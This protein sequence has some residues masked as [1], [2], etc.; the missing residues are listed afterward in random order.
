MR[1]FSG[2]EISIL[3]VFFFFFLFFK[4]LF[5]LVALKH[6]I[7]WGRNGMILVGIFAPF[8]KGFDK[9]SEI[10][11]FCLKDY[12]HRKIIR[13]VDYNCIKFIAN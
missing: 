3:M 4:I 12:L 7:F 10:L 5:L 1:G 8:N 11:N 9:E 6:E 2:N 13:F